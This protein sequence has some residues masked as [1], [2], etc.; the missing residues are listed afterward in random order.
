MVPPIWL[1]EHGQRVPT[2]R[3]H[4]PTCAREW[5]V[6]RYRFEYLSWTGWPARPM[7]IVNSPCEEQTVRLPADELLKVRLFSGRA[8]PPVDHDV[9]AFLIS[10]LT[11]RTDEAVMKRRREG[12][13][14]NRGCE[15]SSCA[16]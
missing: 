12:H 13:H 10:K 3:C 1:N 2:L 4:V 8:A 15:G 14:A 5:P 16:G 11:Q 7:F 6:C 9:P